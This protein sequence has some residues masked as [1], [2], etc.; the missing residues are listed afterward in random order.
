MNIADNHECNIYITEFYK[1]GQVHDQTLLESH[2]VSI[3]PMLS[4]KGKVSV[5]TV[6]LIISDQKF[7]IKFYPSQQLQFLSHDPK[8]KNLQMIIQPILG[9]IIFLQEK[10][11]T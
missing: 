1:L 6:Y 3:V 10:L 4:S 11:K 2:N 9:C 5:V 8:Q 7:T